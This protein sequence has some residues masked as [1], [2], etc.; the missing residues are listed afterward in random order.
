MRTSTDSTIR[1]PEAPPLR[2]LRDLTDLGWTDAHAASFEPHAVAGRTPGRVVLGHRD[3]Y[4][5][6]SP[7]GELRAIVS[8]RFRF[9]AIVASDFPSVGDWVAVEHHGETD[10][11]MIHAV[12]PRRSAFVRRMPGRGT[13]TQVIAANVDLV[14]VV[15]SLNRDLNLR[16]L[17]RYLAASRESGAAAAIVLSK[18]D[19]CGGL[20]ELEDR[21]RVVQTIARGT[22]IVAVSTIDG[23]G[24]DDLVDLLEPRHTMALIG[25][26]G[27]GKSTLVNALAGE[28]LLP[29][30]EVRLDDARGRH[31]T[32]HRQLVRLP[33]GAL[34]LDTPGMREL[35]LIDDAGL[36]EAFA[37]IDELAASCRFSDCGHGAEPGCAVSEAIRNGSLPAE[38]LDSQRK[39]EREARRAQAEQDPRARAEERRRHR[40]MSAAVAYHMRRKYGEDR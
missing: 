17:E 24:M 26:S 9:E 21:R 6:Q 39:L 36:G 19:L 29:V 7:R 34:I 14:L 4:L 28:T 23:R 40:M 1:I 10:E 3:M 33:G 35:G 37:D 32:S 12:L 16:R 38:R 18:A 2:G 20:D 13:S 11:A 27:V 8:G 25:S 30:R 31:T 15:T 5:V 22:P